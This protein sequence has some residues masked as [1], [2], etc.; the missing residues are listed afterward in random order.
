M[1]I[2]YCEI[3]TVILKTTFFTFQC[4]SFTKNRKDNEQKSL[5]NIFS[6][7]KSMNKYFYLNL[8]SVSPTEWSN[9]PNHFVVNLPTNCLNAFDH[10]CGW[11]L[12]GYYLLPLG[13]MATV[14][15]T[16]KITHRLTKIEAAF[17]ATIASYFSRSCRAK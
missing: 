3:A 8:L 9:T 17:M 6:G 2:Y 1:F 11:H 12:K 7:T 10:L 5:Y 16:F 13:Y 14:T 15:Q 4:T